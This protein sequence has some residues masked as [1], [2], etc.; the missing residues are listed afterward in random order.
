MEKFYCYLN[1][2]P[3]VM[4]Y[5]R[6]NFG[7]KNSRLPNAIS[8]RR[9]RILSQMLKN[10]LTKQSHRYD[11]RNKGYMFTNRCETAA[12][13][14]DEVTFATSGFLLSLTDAAN[15]ALFLERRCYTLLLSYLHMRFIF[16]NNLNECIEDFYRQYHYS[17]ETWPSESIRRIWYRDKTF[18]R[19]MFRGFINKQ[20]G[21]IIIVQMKRLGLISARGAQAYEEV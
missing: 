11:N 15:L 10:M 8:F 17:E 7:A 4:Q 2:T 5:L 21:K 14:I 6:V 1:V 13:E 19:N 20:I 16:N 3:F 12:I 18:D 9:D